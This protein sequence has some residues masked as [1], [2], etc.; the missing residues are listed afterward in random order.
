MNTIVQAARV[1]PA[2]SKN[3]PLTAAIFVVV[4][5]MLVYCIV[6]FRR[7]PADVAEPPQMYGS[8]PIELAWTRRNAF[9]GF[10][11]SIAVVGRD[12]G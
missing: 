10:E 3:T 6:R 4:E 1:S 2:D 8:K 5:G 9:C 12:I 7:R 11:R